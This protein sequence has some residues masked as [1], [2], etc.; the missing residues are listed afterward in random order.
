MIDRLRL[1]VEKS[2]SDGLN[3]PSVLVPEMEGL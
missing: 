2:V 3:F 1:D